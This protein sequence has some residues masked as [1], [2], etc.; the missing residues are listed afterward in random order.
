MELFNNMTGTEMVHIPF[1]GS[2]AAMIDLLGGQV[3]LA[4]TS[5]ISGMPHLKTGKLRGLA[6]TTAKRSPVIAEYPTVAESGVPGYSVDG[7]YAVVLPAKTP[8]AIVNKL[9]KE[10]VRLLD[11]PAVIEALAK[12]GAVPA[13][14]T[15]AELHETMRA[16]LA[17]WAKVVKSAG[18]KME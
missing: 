12:D 13:P 7:W 16:E 9:N 5:A 17:K 6:V 1:K 18:L 14:S 2:G 8:A 15:P 4:L 3:Q 10:L 11:A